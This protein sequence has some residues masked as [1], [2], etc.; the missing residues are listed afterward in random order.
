MNEI[1]FGFSRRSK[2]DVYHS[3]FSHIYYAR[4]YQLLMYYKSMKLSLYNNA[5]PVWAKAQLRFHFCLQ[6]KLQVIGL[7]VS[8]CP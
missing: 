7:R 2:D 1:T 4:Y 8:F 3:G 5:T 6:L